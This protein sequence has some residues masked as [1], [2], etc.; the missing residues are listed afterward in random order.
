MKYGMT[1]LVKDG[2]V[3]R[4]VVRGWIGHPFPMNL[5]GGRVVDCLCTDV[6]V[7]DERGLDEEGRST[8]FDKGITV[9][10]TFPE[11]V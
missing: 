5:P 7:I 2:Y 3:D 10:V 4:A 8:S 11:G 9:Y 1:M 6:Q